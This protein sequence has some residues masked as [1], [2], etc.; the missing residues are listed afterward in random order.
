[1]VFFVDGNAKLK[2]ELASRLTKLLQTHFGNEGF[3]AQYDVSEEESL[4]KTLAT[5][6]VFNMTSLLHKYNKLVDTNESIMI[7]K[8]IGLSPTY[9]KSYMMEKVKKNGNDLQVQELEKGFK[10][11]YPTTYKSH[12]LI[13][14]ETT[15]DKEKD[16]I[17]KSMIDSKLGQV[18]RVNSIYKTT[19]G[20]KELSD[21]A[22][23]KIARILFN[24]F[25][26]NIEKTNRESLKRDKKKKKELAKNKHKN[27]Q[28]AG[29]GNSK[30]NNKTKMG[31]NKGNGVARQ[32]NNKVKGK[33]PSKTGRPSRVGKQEKHKSN[34]KRTNG[35]MARQK[36]KNNK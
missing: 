5:T 27:K 35:Y 28:N 17:I 23:T 16:L 20:K 8:I 31:Q 3:K 12:T 22:M 36:M 2:E 25:L 1:M 21:L 33:A 10:P 7:C 4:H 30:T 6:T 34:D 15:G 11:K 26:Y 14:E 18:V 9:L 24:I 32:P 29:K 13:L 19:D